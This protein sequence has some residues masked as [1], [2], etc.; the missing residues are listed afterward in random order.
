MKTLLLV[1][2][3]TA[4]LL[5]AVLANRV[6]TVFTDTDDYYSQGVELW[7][8]IGI[9]VFHL[10]EPE[11]DVRTAEEKA[12]ARDDEQMARTQM[13]ARSTSY[14]L[15]LYG[16]ES[17]GTLWLVTAAQAAVAAWLLRL[18]VR[19]AAPEASGWIYLA[20]M[21]G[22]AAGSTLPFFAGFAMP[23][24]F[25][26]MAVLACALLLL[27]WAGLSRTERAGVLAI[28]WFA[29][30]VHTSHELLAITLLPVGAG[31]LWWLG[32]PR[33]AAAARLLMVAAAVVAAIGWNTG[34]GMYVE[35]QTGERLRHQPFLMAR[36]LADGPGRR[37]L[38][39][40]CARGE[41][42]A[43]CAFAKLPLDDSE[44]IL[45][46]DSPKTGVFLQSDWETRVQLELDEP[47]FMLGVLGYEPWGQLQASFGNFIKQLTLVQVDDPVKDPHYYMTDD[48]WAHTY[49][50]DLIMGVA[51]CGRKGN[52]CPSRMTPELSAWW[53]GGVVG[54]AL[55]VIAVVLARRRLPQ[56]V[57]A[58][59]W[60]ILAGV[61]LNAAITGVLSGPFAR[62]QSRLIW[63]VPAAAGVLLTASRRFAPAAVG[64]SAEIT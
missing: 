42:Y 18:S 50:P 28:L 33:G 4:L 58:W 3:G 31:L 13:A 53:H 32:V 56:R 1:L 44:D 16:L 20:L 46:S 41:T 49:L 39:Q 27:D 26:G 36:T 48:Y 37:Y 38:R 57:T 14:S 21:A 24:V 54:A 34:Y 61:V 51:H 60:L 23:D 59:A 52:A 29:L 9:G 6:P 43:L 10:A 63:L 45:W 19:E 7:E 17:A 22:L 2:A 12:Q 55:L 64:K 11:P 62:Y 40:A 8:K 5:L 25:A 15:F 35:A 47:R 30:V